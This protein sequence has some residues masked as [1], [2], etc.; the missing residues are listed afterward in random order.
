METTKD[1]FTFTR[2]APNKQM[3]FSCVKIEAAQIQEMDDEFVFNR[4]SHNSRHPENPKH[5]KNRETSGSVFGAAKKRRT[6][7]MEQSIDLSTDISLLQAEPECSTASLVRKKTEDRVVGINVPQQREKTKSHEVYRRVLS[8]NVNDLIKECIYF[9]KDDTG[10]AREII[11]HCNSNYFSDIDYR[12]E[13]ELANSRNEQIK[14]EIDK[15]NRVFIEE[16]A[17]NGI[18]ILEILDG[19]TATEEWHSEDEAAS[20]VLA[21][22]RLVAEFEGK[23]KR[24]LDLEGRLRY[25]FENAKEKSDNLLKSIFGSLEEKSVDAIFLLRAMSKLGR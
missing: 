14:S 4:V 16:K 24:L 17:R 10:Y 3:N 2:K 25:F 15:W 6:I 5:V 19:K 22:R 21:Q 9:L 23:A 8:G 13:I 1:G 20:N 12:K 7:Q 11:K 18:T